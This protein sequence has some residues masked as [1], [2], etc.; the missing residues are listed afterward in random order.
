MLECVRVPY[1]FAEPVSVFYVTAEIA[2]SGIENIVQRVLAQEQIAKYSHALRIFIVDPKTA[3]VRNR[4]DG[5]LF[6]F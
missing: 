5:F 4:I 2:D 1:G 6:L 3:Q